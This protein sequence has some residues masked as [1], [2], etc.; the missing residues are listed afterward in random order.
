MGKIY[1]KYESE[2][3]NRRLDLAGTALQEHQDISNLATKDELSQLEGR[4]NE[5]FDEM[6]KDVEED[7]K[8]KQD[9]I[10]DIDAIREGASRGNTALQ[11]V[12]SE[13]VKEDEIPKLV[14]DVVG[15]QF[16]TI[17]QELN[18]IG[19]D[20]TSLESGVKEANDKTSELES[21]TNTKVT[22]LTDRIEI[23]EQGG[24]Y[25][26][27]ELRDMIKGKVDKVEGKQLSTEDFTSELKGK[28][29]GLS[30]YD[31]T[32]LKND[33][34]VLKGKVDDKQDHIEDLEEI[35]NGARLG[36]TALQSHQDISHLATKEEVNAAN[37]KQDEDIAALGE[38]RK[39]L[40][41]Q[42]A[43]NKSRIDATATNVIKLT[44]ELDILK[45]EGDGSIEDIVS[46]EIAKVIA[47]APEDLDTLREIADFI[48]AEAT[49]ATQIAT[50]LDDHAERIKKLE[51]KNLDIVMM[52][53][54][55]Y[56]M[57]PEKENKLYFLYED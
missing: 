16:N 6:S 20:I 38:A 33:L 57:L 30:N 12:P 11:T 22:E 45:G 19:R 56:E 14:N 17:S 1:L 2:E 21:K 35:R 4:T 32:K 18:N 9:V 51:D 47:S 49:E 43:D 26:D 13:Y 15:G 40:S 50:K 27:T 48:E 25:D 28:L 39:N 7:L 24:A 44:E 37:E 46:K 53:E 29:D 8:G 5:K 52:T 36:S 54:S 34:E 31:D 42:I 10:E 3:I 23:L 41:S 55:Q